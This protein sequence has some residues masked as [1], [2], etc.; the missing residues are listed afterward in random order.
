MADKLLI[1]FVLLFS[2]VLPL[3]GEHQRLAV[4]QRTEHSVVMEEALDLSLIETEDEAA[5]RIASAVSVHF[6]LHRRFTAGIDIPFIVYLPLSTDNRYGA[7]AGIGDPSLQTGYT[8]RYLN[9]RLSLHASYSFPLGIWRPYRVQTT[10]I[11]SG[12]GYHSISFGV[13][14]ARIVDPLITSLALSYAVGIP[15]EEAEGHG[16][17]PGDI[18]IT[19]RITEALNHETGIS[20]TISQ[21]IGLA[22]VAVTS[23]SEQT[24]TYSLSIAFSVLW[25]KKPWHMHTSIQHNLSQTMQPPTITTKGGYTIDW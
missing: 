3:Q 12:S 18:D 15:Q 20:L 16:I 10:G 22:Q 4:E 2:V 7:R 25:D 5:F 23:L 9:Y 14:G 11:R 13:N 6:L 17:K 24:P 21:R 19:V 8:F 1:V